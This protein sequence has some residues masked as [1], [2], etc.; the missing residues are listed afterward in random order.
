QTLNSRYAEALRSARSASKDLEQLQ[1]NSNIIFLQSYQTF[2]DQYAE[3]DLKGREKVKS[4]A[5][6][7]YNTQLEWARS[8]Y[9]DDL[10]QLEFYLQSQNLA[11]QKFN[12]TVAENNRINLKNITPEGVRGL[13]KE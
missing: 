8:F 9:K 11:Y 12:T 7:F 13:T 2:A 3:E 6:E 4:Q 5:R 1:N 10:Q